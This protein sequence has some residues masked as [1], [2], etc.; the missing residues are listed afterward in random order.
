M[1]NVEHTR[2]QRVQIRIAPAAKRLIERAAALQN[3]TVSGF[4]VNSALD[5]AS[6]LI[7]EHKR[8]VLDVR[9]WG[10]FLDALLDPPK[11][12]AALC[13]AARTAARVIESAT[14]QCPSPSER[15]RGTTTARA[16]GAAPTRSTATCA[17]RH[18][19]TPGATCRGSSSRSR[20]HSR[21]SRGSTRSAPA[22][23]S[24]RP[25]PKAP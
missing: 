19:K 24:A 12:N 9:D 5:A 17:A 11:P 10:V 21:R 13:E 16:F 2:T 3:T 8:L 15:L 14:A 7:A 20:T 4:V 23:S 6:H 25:C 18:R 22:A 1:A